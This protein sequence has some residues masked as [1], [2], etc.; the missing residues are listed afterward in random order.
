MDS[1]TKIAFCLKLQLE[2]PEAAA[3]PND[4]VRDPEIQVLILPHTY[5]KRASTAKRKE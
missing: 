4:I 1:F 2:H 5:P 3:L